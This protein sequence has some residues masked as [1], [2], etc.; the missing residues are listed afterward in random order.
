NDWIADLFGSLRKPITKALARSWHVKPALSDSCGITFMKLV[1]FF[2]TTTI[3]FAVLLSR[4]QATGPLS[5]KTTI[6]VERAGLIANL[7]AVGASATTQHQEPDNPTPF[8]SASSTHFEPLLM[9]L[10]GATLLTIATG[11]RLKRSGTLLKDH[12][13]NTTAGSL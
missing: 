12:R 11:V 3:I 10:L 1:S 6:A 4:I 9:L 2:A 8:I 5:D 13:T 7:S